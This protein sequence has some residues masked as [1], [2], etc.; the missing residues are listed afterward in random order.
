MERKISSP[1]ITTDKNQAVI[2]IAY[3]AVRFFISLRL[4]V[5]SF[6]QI[7]TGQENNMNSSK[8]QS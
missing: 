8:E 6:F 7:A 5:F 4:L 2:G 3:Y 1:R